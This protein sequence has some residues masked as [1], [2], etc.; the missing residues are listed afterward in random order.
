M[1]TDATSFTCRTERYRLNV[2]ADSVVAACG[3]RLKAAY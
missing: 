2:Y 1:N 3:R